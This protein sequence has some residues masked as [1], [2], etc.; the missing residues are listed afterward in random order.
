M[1]L[2]YWLFVFI[3]EVKNFKIIFYVFDFLG[4]F[5]NVNVSEVSFDEIY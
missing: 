1:L 2:F 3:F 5:F 4:G